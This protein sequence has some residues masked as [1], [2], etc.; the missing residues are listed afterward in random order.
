MK[1]TNFIFPGLLVWFLQLVT[2][3]FFSINNVRPDFIVLLV[4]YWA[5]KHG[6]FTGVLSGT[7]IG[8]VVDLYVSGSCVCE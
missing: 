4:L 5:I 2:I 8:F 1:W 6:R 7:F 3:D